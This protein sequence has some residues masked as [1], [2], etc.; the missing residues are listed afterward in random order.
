MVPTPRGGRS[1]ETVEAELRSQI[2]ARPSRQRNCTS[3]ILLTSTTEGFG[4]RFLALMVG[5]DV[6]LGVRRREI[7]TMDRGLLVLYASQTGCA[8]EARS[9]PYTHV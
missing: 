6:R 2:A 4:F 5:L 1:R 3:T 7:C 8:E 9:P